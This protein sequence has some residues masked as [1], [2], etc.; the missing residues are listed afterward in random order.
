MRPTEAQRLS[1]RSSLVAAI[2]E[3]DTAVLME[4]MPPIDYDTLATRDDLART[5]ADLEAQIDAL[6]TEM[7]G[8]F[9]MIDARFAEIDARFVAITAEL[10][11]EISEVQAARCRPSAGNCAARW[12]R[13]RRS[14]SAPRSDR[15]SAS[16]ASSS[17]S[18]DPGRLTDTRGSARCST[19]G[20]IG[21]RASP[22]GEEALAAQ[23]VVA[24]PGDAVVTEPASEVQLTR[25]G[26]RS[27]SAHPAYL[28]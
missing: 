22:S 18:A 26:R 9:T 5:A 27:A 20:S 12:Q 25:A 16:P 8:R 19:I 7:D 15:C 10:R 11:G 23:Q 14:S 2:G 13:R 17:D 3:S 24:R 1:L 28:R 4:A 6:R 21:H